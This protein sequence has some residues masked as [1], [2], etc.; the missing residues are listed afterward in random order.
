MLWRQV[1][2]VLEIFCMGMSLCCVWKRGVGGVN[3]V[4]ELPEGI[5]QH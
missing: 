5:F 4:I 2:V 3:N 1:M